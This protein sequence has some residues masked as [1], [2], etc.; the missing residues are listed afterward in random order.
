L[1]SIQPAPVIKTVR[2]I[3]GIV[4]ETRRTENL[5]PMARA[6]F[7]TIK[8]TIELPGGIGESQKVTNQ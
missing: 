6:K 8:K 2:N 4:L 3:D 7:E 1:D 5:T